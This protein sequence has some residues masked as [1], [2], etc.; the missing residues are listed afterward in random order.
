MK[1]KIDLI[2]IHCT[3]TPHNTTVASIQNHWKNTLKWKSPGYHFL[4][5]QFGAIH[6]LQPLDLPSNGVR[7]FNSNSSMIKAIR[8]AQ[9]YSSPCKPIIQGHRDF[10][11]VAKACPQFHAKIEFSQL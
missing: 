2:V 1:R 5:D 9:A 8:E 7:G 4:I 3:A 10:P 6:G 11:N